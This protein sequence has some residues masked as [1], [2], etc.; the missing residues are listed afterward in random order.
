M[1]DNDVKK[2]GNYLFEKLSN[3]QKNVSEL[4]NSLDSAKDEVAYLQMIINRLHLCRQCLVKGSLHRYTSKENE[5]REACPTC[6]GKGQI[7]PD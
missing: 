3:A 6:K 4:E 5:Y 2:I 7:S 1:V